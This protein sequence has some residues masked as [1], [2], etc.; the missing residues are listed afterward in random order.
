[1]TTGAHG[2]GGGAVLCDHLYG[3]PFG[4]SGTGNLSITITTGPRNC[5]RTRSWRTVEK[6]GQNCWCDVRSTWRQ[7][8]QFGGWESLWGD[9]LRSMQRRSCLMTGTCCC[10]QGRCL[11][12]YLRAKDTGINTRLT[13]PFSFSLVMALPLL[14]AITAPL[15]TTDVVVVHRCHHCHL[16]CSRGGQSYVQDVH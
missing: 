2:N 11:F 8:M 14:P 6:R 9:G 3:P 4:A 13:H 1:M 10:C 12:F 5:C 7:M 15:T 16:Q